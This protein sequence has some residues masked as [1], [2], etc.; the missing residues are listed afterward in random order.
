MVQLLTFLAVFFHIL[1]VSVFDYDYV[2]T[3]NLFMILIKIRISN[4]CFDVV[5]RR[6]RMVLVEGSLNGW[7]RAENVLELLEQDDL[8]SEVNLSDV[9]EAV[10]NYGDLHRSRSYL[11]QEC[12]TC[13]N[14]YPA[15]KVGAQT[16]LIT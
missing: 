6:I 7:K 12:E 5:Q 9:I 15:S 14:M 8:G 13:Y 10:K 11:Q 4:A 16:S 2:P 3:F 1:R